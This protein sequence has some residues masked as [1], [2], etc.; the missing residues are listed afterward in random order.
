MELT[1]HQSTK[2]AQQISPATQERPA[3]D[4]ASPCEVTSRRRRQRAADLREVRPREHYESRPPPRSHT[5]ARTHS[6]CAPAGTGC[7]SRVTRSVAASMAK[8]RGPVTKPTGISNTAPTT[9]G[10]SKS[11][12]IGPWQDQRQ[13][14]RDDERGGQPE[15]R[16]QRHR[17][18]PERS[19]VLPHH[20]GRAA[21][22]SRRSNRASD[23][24]GAA[25]RPAPRRTACAPPRTKPCRPGSDHGCQ[26]SLPR[27]PATPPRRS[28]SRPLR[29]RSAPRTQGGPGNQSSSAS[30]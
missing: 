13:Q 22:L 26:Q 20:L 9:Q 28:R 5:E 23:P 1:V 29:H 14:P 30:A 17:A 6:D 24:G 11:I 15:H 4:Q 10:T 16:R 19:D 21:L 18:G 25:T 2:Q 3:T 27:W 8:I 7:R 12:P